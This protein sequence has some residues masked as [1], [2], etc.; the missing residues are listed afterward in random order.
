MQNF[1]WK[2]MADKEDILIQKEIGE[3]SCGLVL[4]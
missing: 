1:G 4:A 2:I 3:S